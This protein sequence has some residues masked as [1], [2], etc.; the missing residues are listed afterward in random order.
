[1]A[2]FYKMTAEK[3]KQQLFTFGNPEKAAHSKHFFKTGKG[4]Y[5]EGDLFIG[6]TVPETRK[7]AK[8]HK[9]IPFHEL[10]LL[11]NDDW[12][13]CRLCA[14]MIL[15]AKFQKA[16]DLRR[17]EIVDFY[18]A[19]THCINNWDLV[20]LSSHQI[21]GEWLKHK[22]D[23]SLLY[24]LAQSNLLWEQRI[25]VVSTMA[26]IRNNDFAD[27]LR[28][29]EF[30]LSH[31]H[32]LIHKACG[33]MLRETGKHNEAVLIDF[34][35]RHYRLMPRTMLRYTIERLTPEQKAKYMQRP[36]KQISP[37]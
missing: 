4:Q 10:R 7:V 13:E 22:E 11:L 36:Q 20:D 16:D 19:H 17:K 18:L 21:I 3:I 8:I 9:D 30:F 6:C 28:L 5:G 32:D 12:H 33:W 26:F 35:D 25:A 2:T 37:K 31:K 29:S 23:R 24:T 34:L 1:M 27:T 14:L 15:V